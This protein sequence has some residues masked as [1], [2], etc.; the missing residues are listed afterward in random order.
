MAQLNSCG[1]SEAEC[2]ALRREVAARMFAY[3][4]LSCL[5]EW[6]HLGLPDL[7]HASLGYL[8][9]EKHRLSAHDFEVFYF[10][11]MDIAL[12]GVIIDT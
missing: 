3:N 5:W 12:E 10:R 11:A 2:Q 4:F 8:S 7:L 1:I 9:G 6:V